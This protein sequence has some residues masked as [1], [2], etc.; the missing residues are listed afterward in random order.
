V[1][2]LV[3]YIVRAILRATALVALV[4]VAVASVVEFVGQL[5]DVGIESYGLPQALIYVALRIPHKLFD[6]L[7]AAALIGALLGLGNLA[8][9][10]ELVVMR[11]SGISQFRLVAA[12]GTAGVV[13]LVV[14]WLLGESLA[15]SLGDYARR[16]RTDALFE[17]VDTAS[18]RTTWHREG[19][20]Y[21]MIEEPAQGEARGKRVTAFESAG[22]TALRRVEEAELFA[23]AEPDSEAWDMLDYAETEFTG[24]GTTARRMERLRR[25]VGLSPSMLEIYE[26]R[27]DLLELPELRQKIRYLES[28]GLDAGRFLAAYWD[29]IASSVSVVLMTMLALPFVLGSLRSASAS[30]RMIVGLVIG[31]GYY[32]LG[33]LAANSRE[34]FAL[35]PVVAAWAPSAVLFVITALAVAR[36]R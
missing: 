9:H 33:E 3:S 19:D 8:V 22:V 17:D 29:R 13:L 11:A 14:M 10:R 21:F 4:L 20:R 24:T 7:P 28:R 15:P 31:L 35:D 6:V 25:D 18:A 36:L 5:G 16:A 23:P 27:V 32:V 12:A 1:N 34:V 30:A 2:L 26:D